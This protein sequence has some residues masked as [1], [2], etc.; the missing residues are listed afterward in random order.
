MKGFSTAL[1]AIVGVVL[2]I[3]ACVTVWTSYIVPVV[4]AGSYHDLILVGI[5]ILLLFLGGGLVVLFIALCGAVFA[6]LFSV[7]TPGR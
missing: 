7:L 2:A 4:P 3:W 5:G 1:G 6:A